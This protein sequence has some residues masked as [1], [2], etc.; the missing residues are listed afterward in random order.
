MMERI[1][2]A[3]P[4]P[5]GR[6]PVINIAARDVDELDNE[7]TS[8]HQI[9][10]RGFVRREQRRW[11][12]K[13]SQGQMLDLPRKSIEAT[14]TAPRSGASVAAR[15]T[16]GNIQAMQQ[17]ISDGAWSD[18]EVLTIRRGE[19]AQILGRPDGVLIIDGCDYPKQGHDS[20]GVA[21][22]YCGPLGKVANCQASVVTAYASEAGATLLDRR[23]FMPEAWFGEAYAERR[24]KCGVPATVTFKTKPELAAEMFQSVAVEGVLPFSWVTMDEG[25]GAAGYLLDAIHQQHKWYLAEIPRH[26]QAWRSRPKVRPP[27]APAGIGRPPTRWQLA[28]GTPAAQRVDALAATLQRLDWH[29][30]IIREGSKGRLA[31]EIAAL[32]V[33]MLEEGLPGRDEWLVVRRHIGEQDNQ[34]WKFYRSN[35]P[36]GTSLKTLARLTGWRWPIETVIEECKDELGLDHY[37]VRGWVGWHHHTTMTLLAHSFLV[38]LRVKLGTQAPALTVSQTRQLLQVVLPKRKYDSQAALAE[39]ERIQSQNHA[40]YRSHQKRRRRAAKSPPPN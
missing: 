11:A 38:R 16:D 5:S 13:Y 31:V 33:T 17:F 25:Y 39:L 6:A 29:G 27:Q 32:R 14:R 8:Y 35:A 24:E 12:L 15:L 28:E 18:D 36:A 23:L 2:R 19:I 21:R 26:K 7:L 30:Y 1:G 37:E 10:A 20:V 22:Q 40:A 3:V 34:H 9:F 4:P